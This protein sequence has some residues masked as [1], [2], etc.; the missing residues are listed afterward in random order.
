MEHSEKVR[1]LEEAR[2]QRQSAGSVIYPIANQ[3]GCAM[4]PFAF[5]QA[6]EPVALQRPGVV[7]CEKRAAL[8]SRAASLSAH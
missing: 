2:R 5:A 1:Q 6:A 3:Q 7:E 8:S 4:A